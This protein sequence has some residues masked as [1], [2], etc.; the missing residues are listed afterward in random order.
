M[1]PT[2]SNPSARQ[3]GLKVTLADSA[4]FANFY[5]TDHP[6]HPNHLAKLALQ[7]LSRADAAHA[8]IYLWGAPGCG[9]SHLL[10]ACCQQADLDGQQSVYLPL[11]AL[12]GADPAAVFERLE[13]CDLLCLDDIDAVSGR[14]DWDF[15]LFH[16]LNR[17]RERSS[18]RLLIAAHCPLASLPCSLPDVTS[19]LGWGEA[20]RLQVLD[21]DERLA[22]LV[23]RALA[24]GLELQPEALQFM[25]TRLSRDPRDWFAALDLL[26]Q[27]SLEQQRK[28][29]IPFIKEVL[30]I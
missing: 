2:P 11:Y 3:L 15:Q 25:A 13:V 14:A 8:L 19:R 24:R 6:E 10:Q 1:N 9:A 26:D 23:Q 30:N 5:C 22:A 27:A 17:W 21:E 29:T 28:L 12:R 16:F 20:Y 18:G 4:T 7:K